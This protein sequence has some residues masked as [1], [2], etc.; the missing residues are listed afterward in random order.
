MTDAIEVPVDLLRRS[1]EVLLRHLGTVQGANVLLDS[2]YFWVVAAGQQ[3]DIYSEP[4]EFTVGQISEC[5]DN[6]K[7]ILDDESTATSFAL[8]WLADVLHAVGRAVVE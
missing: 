5:L 1:A 2:D 3:N 8:V 4:T 7:R 6:L